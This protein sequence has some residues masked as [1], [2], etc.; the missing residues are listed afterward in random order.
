MAIKIKNI[1]GE[2]NTNN[3]QGL[4]EWLIKIVIWMVVVMTMIYQ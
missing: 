3:L 2:R 4:Q 1:N